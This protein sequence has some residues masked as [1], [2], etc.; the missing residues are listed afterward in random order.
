MENVEGSRVGNGR[1]TKDGTNKKYCGWT[2][3][4]IEM[5]NSFL[6]M[7]KDN[8]KEGWAHDMEAQVME[9]LK[10]RYNQEARRHT[11]A[12]CQCRK[13]RRMS[14]HYKSDEN[15]SGSDINADNDLSIAFAQ[16]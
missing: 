7:V 15:E 5:Y 9:A 13:K 16:V 11:Q 3:E 14:D 12:V 6:K 1:L 4:G 10:L 2:R 8:C